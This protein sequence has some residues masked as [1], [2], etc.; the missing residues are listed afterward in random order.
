[1]E[2]MNIEKDDIPLISRFFMAIP[3]IRHWKTKNTIR[4]WEKGRKMLDEVNRSYGYLTAPNIVKLYNSGKIDQNAMSSLAYHKYVTVQLFGNKAKCISEHITVE[5]AMLRSKPDYII[6]LVHFPSA[7]DVGQNDVV[8]FVVNPANKAYS[9]TWEWSVNQNHMI[10]SFE[11]K[12]HLNYGVCNDKI[13]F[14]K[15]IVELSGN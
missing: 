7:K 6:Y 15:R 14:V 3:F 2:D 12:S 10:C 9:Y 13:E 5:R 11:D 1:M 8:A 4:D